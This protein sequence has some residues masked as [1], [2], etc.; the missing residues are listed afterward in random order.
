ME[1]KEYLVLINGQDKTASV[2]SVCFQ[3]GMYEVVYK[4]SSKCYSYRAEKVKYIEAKE[5]IDAS[6]LIVTV[7][8]RTIQKA[9]TILDFDPFYRILCAEGRSYTYPKEKVTLQKNCLADE[10]QKNVFDYFKETAQ[11]VS[12]VTENGQNILQ[13]RYERSKTISEETVLSCYFNLS[14]K[15]VIR[16]LPETIIYPFGLNQSQKTAVENALSSQISVIQG[17]PGTG[18][19]QTI[20]NIISN[21]VRQGKTVAVVSNNNSATLNV[22]EKL[23]KKGLSF[24]TAFLGSR[25]NKDNFLKEQSGHYPNMEKWT[26]EPEKKKQLNQKVTSLSKELREMLNAKNRIAAIEQELLQLTPE[27]HYF[28][29]Y[30]A[31]CTQT[32]FYKGIMP[33]EKVLDLPVDCNTLTGSVNL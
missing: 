19:T 33:S 14:K 9:E 24:L 29:E 30:Y 21:V 22:A 5:K 1:D 6:D 27:Q 10:K 7:D 16:E 18:K 3:K 26:M 8:G 23:E 13:M 32:I 20:L 12:L 15:P 11:A 4:G 28:E 17:P 25:D 2:E 31:T